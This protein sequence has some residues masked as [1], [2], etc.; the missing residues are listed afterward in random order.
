M[1][2]DFIISEIK[3]TALLNNGKPLGKA[4]FSQETG[5]REYDWYG[6][7]WSR[8]SDA[9]KDAGLEPNE[10]QLPF[11][12]DD[13][14]K[15]AVLLMGEINRFPTSGDF[16]LKAKHDKTFPSH[17]TFER[18]G[19]KEEFIETVRNYCV[20]NGHLALLDLCPAG[21]KSL[22]SDEANE[23]ENEILG[24][25]YLYKAKAHYKIGRTN[26]VSRR[27]REIKLQLPFEAEL[28]HRITTDDP[29]GIER[30][31]HERFSDRRLNGEWF[32]LTAT[33]IKAFKR[34]KFM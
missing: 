18:F 21:K 15:S 33:D 19:R 31:W 34:R 4:R 10:L 28:I 23:T 14:L 24:F 3:R 22:R 20:E 9:V 2:K 7:H 6:K 27:N 8:W 13:L 11:H 32:K 25:V 17:S 29:I 16:R 30:Y 5:I 12:S 26:D 1:T